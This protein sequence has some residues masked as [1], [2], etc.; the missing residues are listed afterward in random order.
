MNM[1]HQKLSILL[2][3]PVCLCLLS[4]ESLLDTKPTDFYTEDSFW[5]TA[6]HAE[7]ATTS[8][9][10]AL[11]HNDLYNEQTPFM[12][13]VMTPNAYHKDNFQSAHD[14][15]I[16]AHSA[17]T[18]GMNLVTWRGCYRG[19]GRCNMVIDRVP[20]IEMD[21]ALKT[22][23]VGEAKFLRAF[24]F[25]K[26]N[27]LFNGVP[28]VVTSP[29]GADHSAL[30]RAA[31]AEVKQQILQDLNDAIASLPADYPATSSGRATKGAA[32][33][34]K[35]QV[36][37]QDHEYTEVVSAIDELIALEKYALFPDY[38]GLFRKANEGNSEI[39]FDVRFKSPQVRNS[40]DIIHA[41]YN[42]QAPLQELV[43]AYQMKDGLSIEESPLYDPQNPYANRDPRLAQ[44][45]VY[46][47]APWRNR[48]ADAADL[49][50]TGY[51]FRKYT[52]YNET[53]VGTIANS[54]VNYVILRYADV[55]LMYAEA[56]NELHG[57]TQAVY[58]AVNAVRQRPSVDMP[59]LPA[60]LD[61]DAMREAIRLERR[62]ELAGEGAYF[63]DIRRWKTIEQEMVGPV[64]THSGAVIETRN[65]DPQR[66]YYWP[67]PYTE[68]DL[69][70]ALIQ[71]PNY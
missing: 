64:H 33:A 40:Y 28:L 52:E 49:H 7:E 2:I 70:P 17:T 13:E 55:L 41:Q 1:R 38:N 44:S 25:Q 71:N 53:T 14:F 58:E 59:A 3:I 12:F 22:R 21:E 15:A 23:L 56:L 10:Q 54:D 30:P 5:K 43:E 50:Q 27:V 62:I 8:A 6:T 57:A 65:F 61:K 69:N 47:G 45:I 9:Y 26:L 36:H 66:D 18:I 51:T 19:I 46:L 37:L 16:G 4:C 60:G 24:Y 20:A 11:L 67:I 32:L 29:N 35:A 68:I 63:Y 42:T 39:I 48:V 31:Y 34:L